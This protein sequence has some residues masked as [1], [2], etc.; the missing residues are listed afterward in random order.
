MNDSS[1]SVK[2]FLD[3]D[4]KVTRWPARR[5][6]QRDQKAILDYLIGKFERDVIYS[7]KE[8]NAILN[9]WHTFGD[10]ALL[11]RELYDHEYLDRTPDGKQYWL[12]KPHAAE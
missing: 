10:W 6:V 7:E 1:D 4:G 3:A 11:R 8:V 2:R 9:T 12:R 5:H